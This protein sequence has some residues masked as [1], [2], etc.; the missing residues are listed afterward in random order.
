ML[1][2]FLEELFLLFLVQFFLLFEF[3]ISFVF[4]QHILRRYMCSFLGKVFVLNVVN[5]VFIEPALH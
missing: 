1:L 4:Q 3:E 2:L 5:F